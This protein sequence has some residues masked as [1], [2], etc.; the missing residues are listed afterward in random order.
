MTYEEI[1]KEL[2]YFD[3]E[4]YFVNLMPQFVWS[5]TKK[6]VAGYHEL[7]TPWNL[8]VVM[9]TEAVDVDKKGLKVYLDKQGVTEEDVLV[10]CTNQNYYPKEKGNWV[11]LNIIKN[12]HRKKYDA[13]RTETSEKKEEETPRRRGGLI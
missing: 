10:F 12:V 2:E 13:R 11:L 9:D 1:E 5:Q 6:Q 8:L 7:S 4:V 3:G